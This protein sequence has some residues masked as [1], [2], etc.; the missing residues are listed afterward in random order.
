MAGNADAQPTD[1]VQSSNTRDEPTVEATYFNTEDENALNQLL[2]RTESTNN[3]NTSEKSGVPENENSQ[4]VGNADLDDNADD[5]DD[6]EDSDDDNF[7]VLIKP[8]K[9]GAYK[10]GN[11]YQA[12]SLQIGTQ[13]ILCYLSMHVLYILLYTFLFLGSKVIRQGIN[14]NDPGNIQG[15]PTTEFSTSVLK[16]EDKPWKQPGADITDYFNYGF[17]E[18]TWN[19]YV[20]KQR[21]LRQEYA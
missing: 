14:L 19:Q 12:R 4:D 6:A 2:G 10:T 17:T 9:V 11:T 18:D 16:D 1:E 20:E 8:T 21:I 3:I 15:V 13:G 7:D 5:E